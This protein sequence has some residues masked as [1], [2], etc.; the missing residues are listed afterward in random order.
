MPKKPTTENVKKALIKK[1]KPWVPDWKNALSSG[2]TLVNLAMTSRPGVAFT[3]GAFY[4][5]VGDS[6]SGK[7][8]IA[9]NAL[10][11]ASIHPAYKNHRLIYDAPERGA[12]MDVEAFFG[13]ALAERLEWKY[14]Q[15]VEDFYYE[16]DD[17]FKAGVP[18]L[19]VEDSETS[20]D[21]K[22]AEEKFQ[23]QK[24]AYRKGKEV[25]GSYGDGKAKK[26]SANLRQVISKLELSGS[27]LFLISQ[28]RDNI[29]FGAQYN[30]KTRAGG[31]ALTFYASSEIWTSVK[32]SLTKTVRGKTRKIGNILQ[33][34]VKKNRDTGRE[35]D[36]EI[37]H[38]PSVGF[39]DLGSCIAY[40][41]EEKHWAKGEKGSKI[42]ASEFNF[43]GSIEELVKKVEE[44]DK[45]GQLRLLVND[46]WQ[47][48]EEQCSITRKSRY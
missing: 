35:P 48:I 28:T 2:S 20:L 7:T 11:E 14:S 33:V 26:H 45:E 16:L 47:D 23:E 3:P 10:A 36:V 41:L 17:L 24:T 44:E 8:F 1:R 40:L 30:P 9:L 18:F 15:T 12:R 13:K 21:S 34:K 39:D 22:D 25:A 37:H 46:V 29:G 27:M 4:L 31:R 42:T 32:G 19:Y 5:L 38:Y 43:T 6:K